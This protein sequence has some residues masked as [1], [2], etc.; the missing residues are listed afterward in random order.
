[1]PDIL[2]KGTG[3]ICVVDMYCIQS[4]PL[5]IHDGNIANKYTANL[6]AVTTTLN[7]YVKNPPT[8]ECDFSTFIFVICR[9]F[10]TQ[11]LQNF[12]CTFWI[13]LRHKFDQ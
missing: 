5:L 10:L 9:M 1:M 11:L 13:K 6:L 8:V 2:L 3:G 12:V 4:C 7:I